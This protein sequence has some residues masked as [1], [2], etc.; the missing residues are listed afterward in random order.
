[1][2]QVTPEHVVEDLDAAFFVRVGQRQHFRHQIGMGADGA[3][4]EDDQVARQDVGAFDGDANGDLLIRP[5]QEVVGAQADALAAD[6]VHAVVDD[7]A[8]ALGH[9][10]FHD[11]RDDRGLFAQ[12][13]GACGHAARRIHHVGMAADARQRFFDAF[14]LADRHA[15]LAAHARIAAH[16]AG[17]QLGHPG[18]GGG[19]RNR[20]ARRQAFHQHAPALARHGRA[21]DDEVQRH[22][23]IGA[24]GGPIS[25]VGG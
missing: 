2:S 9:V 5:A 18:V 4:A 13:H 17:R 19:Q 15:E 12:V 14:E 6:Y 11:R 25:G 1:M 20:T 16:G 24:A 3:L 7:L 21:T 23:D 8:R 10:V 22:E